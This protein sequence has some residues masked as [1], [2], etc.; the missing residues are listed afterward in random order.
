MLFLRSEKLLFYTSNRK[1]EKNMVIGL[2]N[3]IAFL[4]IT[5]YAIYLFTNIVYSRVTFIKMGKPANL[6]KDTQKRVNEVL[7]NVFGQRKLF[8][9]RKSGVMHVIMFYGF[10]IL[11]FGAIELI[12]KG[13]FKGF[14]YPIGTAQKFFSV[15]KKIP[16]FLFLL[17]VLYAFYRRYIEKLKRLKRG[18]KSGLVIIFL[19]TLVLS[20]FLSLS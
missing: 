7:V 5:G 14:E 18:F 12:I 1:G 11:Q 19:T 2:I 3:F 4:G 9:D 13:F 8:K 10:I 17:A 16:I 20:I 6:K 15:S